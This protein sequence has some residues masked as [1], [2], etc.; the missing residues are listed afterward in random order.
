MQT[1]SRHCTV[2]F[3]RSR[4]QPHRNSGN[5]SPEVRKLACLLQGTSIDERWRKHA[6]DFH[7]FSYLGT[8]GSFHW[9][10]IL[11]YSLLCTYSGERGVEERGSSSR[12]KCLIWFA[13]DHDRIR[14]S[15]GDHCTL[16]CFWSRSVWPEPDRRVSQNQIRSRMVLH[17]MIWA[18][19]KA[20][21]GSVRKQTLSEGLSHTL[22]SYKTTNNI[23]I[24]WKGQNYIHV[25]YVGTF[26]C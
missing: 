10:T 24:D 15:L 1:W 18:A 14:S 22:T 17:N 11:F 16:A 25:W 3:W 4:R 7:R 9:E 19:R 2:R 8:L 12:W 20:S 13:F 21:S 26:K 23:V 5:S 6:A